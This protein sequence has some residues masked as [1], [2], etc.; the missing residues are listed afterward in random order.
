[1]LN[2]N[3]GVFSFQQLIQDLE[4]IELDQLQSDIPENVDAELAHIKSNLTAVLAFLTDAPADPQL[5]AAV[6]MVRRECMSLN[7]TILQVRVLH[8]FRLHHVADSRY[9]ALAAAQYEKL[10]MAVCQLCQIS[11]PQLTEQLGSAL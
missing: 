9:A 10:T 11:A 5:S 7:L 2:K 6:S 4:H 8:F 1:M 3:A